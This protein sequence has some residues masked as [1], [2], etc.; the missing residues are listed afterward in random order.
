MTESRTIKVRTSLSRQLSRPGGRSLADAERLADAALQTHRADT[1]SE[2]GRLVSELEAACA[3]RTDGD[4]TRVY[5]VAAALVDLAGFFDTGVFY[6][7]AY[8][9]CDLTDRT[10]ERGLWSWEAVQVHVQTLRLLHLAGPGN[11][12]PDAA[13]L[14]A[15]LRR[16]V[17]TVLAD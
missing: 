17:G 4:R 12:S 16:V 3:A 8:S 7:A 14:L 13:A 2:L 15:G 5:A 9:L 11:P 10:R 1:L 6:D